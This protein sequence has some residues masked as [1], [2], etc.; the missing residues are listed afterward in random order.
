[1]CPKDIDYDLQ[2]RDPSVH[3]PLQSALLLAE[4]RFAAMQMGAC[5]SLSFVYSVLTSTLLGALWNVLLLS[6]SH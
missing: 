3:I 5:V 6:F 2:V 1:M 4:S